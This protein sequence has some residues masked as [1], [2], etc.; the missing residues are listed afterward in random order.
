MCSSDLSAFSISAFAQLWPWGGLPAQSRI[1][2]HESPPA[3]DGCARSFDVGSWMF[4]VRVPSKRPFFISRAY[5]NQSPAALQ[6]SAASQ[7]LTH[8]LPHP[9]PELARSQHL[10]VRHPRENPP[11]QFL[12][13]GRLQS[14]LQPAAT[15]LPQF[16]ARVAHP[17]AD[18]SRAAACHRPVR[19]RPTAEPRHFSHIAWLFGPCQ[20]PT[21]SWLSQNCQKN[22]TIIFLTTLALPG[23]MDPMDES[24]KLFSFTRAAS[25]TSG[26]AKNQIPFSST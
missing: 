18:W 14:E 20:L 11:R 26:R 25:S 7:S 1:T 15:T 12:A 3:L 4:D 17:F 24:G 2:N 8:P 22:A 19:A 6:S 23:E 9:V 21:P 16:L 13:T 5:P 10:D